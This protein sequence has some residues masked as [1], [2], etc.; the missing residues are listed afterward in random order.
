MVVVVVVREV[1]KNKFTERAIFN[2]SAQNS[3]KIEL[4]WAQLWLTV[5]SPEL[6]LVHVV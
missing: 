5:A 2:I 6:R 1:N 3:G 4:E